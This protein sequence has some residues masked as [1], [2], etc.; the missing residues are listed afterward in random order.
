MIRSAAA[1]DRRAS[2]E[3]DVSNPGGRHLTVTRLDYELAH[4]ETSFPV[5]TG[6]WTGDRDL[7]ARGHAT[8]VIDAP[9]DAEPIEPDSHLLHL[10][11]ELFFTDRTGF[12]GLRSM[13]LTR[14]PFHAEVEARGSTP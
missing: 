4:G 5:A 2:L 3:L 10:S 7:P 1:D 14:T 6:S 12:L 9:F 11:G 8:I 13:D